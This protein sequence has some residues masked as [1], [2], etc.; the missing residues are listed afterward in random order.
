MKLSTKQF[1]IKLLE[2]ELDSEIINDNI[3]NNE[4]DYVIDLINSSQDFIKCCGDWCDKY[5]I[6]EKISKLIGIKNNQ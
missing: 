5:I 6:Q 2:N 3:N 4:I 1:I